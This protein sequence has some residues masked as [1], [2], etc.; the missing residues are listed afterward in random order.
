[1]LTGGGQSSIETQSERG[2]SGERP[3]SLAAYGP[4]FWEVF[5][6][7]LS[8]GMT[9]EEFWDGDPLL[10]RCY[11]QA[12]KLRQERKNQDAWIQG[13]YIYEALVDAAPVFRAF[14]KKG[15]KPVPYRDQPFELYRRDRE[16]P[17]EPAEAKQKEQEPSQGAMA[18]M[19]MF[20]AAT[21]RKFETRKEE[22][23][24]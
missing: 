23:A 24:E 20:A 11:R 22:S 2:G 8:L 21:N 4:K 3:A 5:P 6:Y 14:G 1:M 18:Y 17:G 15:T 7:Y 13:A 19:Q 16:R 10:A 12:A 9:P